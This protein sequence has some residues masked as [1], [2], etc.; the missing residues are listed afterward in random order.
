MRKSGLISLGSTTSDSKLLV[1]SFLPRTPQHLP[2][3]PGSR[4][5]GQEES[6]RVQVRVLTSALIWGKDYGDPRALPRCIHPSV[7]ARVKTREAAI[8]VPI[9]KRPALTLAPHRAGRTSRPRLLAR[10]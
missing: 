10:R 6:E 8:F 1:D 2:A 5:P 7:L 9:A 3:L 4:E